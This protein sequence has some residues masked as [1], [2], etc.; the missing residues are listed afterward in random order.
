MDKRQSK[1]RR[2]AAVASLLMLALAST[3]WAAPVALAQTVDSLGPRVT[4]AAGAVDGA[5][6]DVTDPVKKTLDDASK[7]VNDTTK[8]VDDTVTQTT[9]TIEELTQNGGES[10]NEPGT[11]S[12]A[13]APSGGGATGP[14]VSPSDNGGA[15]GTLEGAEG[16]GRAD[17]TRGGARAKSSRSTPPSRRSSDLVTPL[18]RQKP[19]VDQGLG[20]A[21]LET[22]ERLAFPLM[23]T[24]LVVGFLV[25]QHRMDSKDPKL[26]LA[27]HS[28]K[29]DLLSFQ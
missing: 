9:N 16:R 22:A 11:R 18:E 21:A 17:R 24:L 27:P 6:K 19:A 4:D 20:E 2:S 10:P 28:A 25:L 3:V 12:N 26:T 23:L 5:V 29:Q 15:P 8:V 1:R 7:T 13:P 14:V